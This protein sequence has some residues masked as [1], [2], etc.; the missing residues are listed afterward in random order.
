MSQHKTRSALA[1]LCGLV[2]AACALAG[3]GTPTSYGPVV[4]NEDFTTIMRRMEQAKPQVMRRHRELLERRYDLTD[5]S[6]GV[7][8]TGGRPV[9]TR[10]RVKLK[11][12]VTWDML[13]GLSPD[14]IRRRGIFPEG[15]MPLPHPN[16]PE[17]GMVFP[18]Y[19]IDEVPLPEG[20]G[21]VL[22]G[23]VSHK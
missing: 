20:E 1:A 6:E 7:T 16:H 18:Q 8:M 4:I 22:E 12:G 17:G 10:I 13:A 9:Q 14:E 11:Q 21:P 2:A 19:H 3:D 5:Y 15:F 23:P